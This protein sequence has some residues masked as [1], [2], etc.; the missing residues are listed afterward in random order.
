MTR[1]V[2]A[3]VVVAL[4][5]IAGLL[6]A[7]VTSGASGAASSITVLDAWVRQPVPPGTQAAAYFTVRNDGPAAD[8]LL[9]VASPIG[10]ATVLHAVRN[11]TMQEVADGV[12]VPAHGSLRFAVGAGHVMIEGV[13]RPLTAGEVVPLALTFER[14]GT[15]T[16]DARV[17][18][19]L[20]PAPSAT[21]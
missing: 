16:V 4:L 17:V 14:F 10:A 8:R 15:V 3:G 19:Y 12:V 20:D 21:G 11:G 9:A 5:G 18:G 2:L 13:S 7:T 6:R 1:S